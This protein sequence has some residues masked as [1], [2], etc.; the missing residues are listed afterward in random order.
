MDPF[1]VGTK[2]T[3]DFISVPKI[4]MFGARGCGDEN[5][6]DAEDT[7]EPTSTEVKGG[8]NILFDVGYGSDRFAPI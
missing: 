4:G 5:R 7:S 3:G 6:D 8:V 1:K 2:G